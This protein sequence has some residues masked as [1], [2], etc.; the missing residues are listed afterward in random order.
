LK[1]INSHQWLAQ[2]YVRKWSQ[3]TQSKMTQL[4]ANDSSRA[5]PA[6]NCRSSLETTAAVV[7]AK[8]QF[9]EVLGS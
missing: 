4:F 5:L 7:A 2:S 6:E 3:G 9:S 8:V 1:A